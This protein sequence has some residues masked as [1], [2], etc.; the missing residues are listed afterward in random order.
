MKSFTQ[1]S[2]YNQKYKVSLKKKE[3]RITLLKCNDALI[4]AKCIFHIRFKDT[5]CP[6]CAKYAV[7]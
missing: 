7:V 2:T 1:I 4:N 5:V 6:S 3:V